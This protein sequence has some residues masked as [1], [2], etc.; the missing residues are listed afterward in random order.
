MSN[1]IAS[2]GALG[3]QRGM[4]QVERAAAAVARPPASAADPAA[5][6]V[7]AKLG[8]LQVQASAKV[9]ETADE[10]LGRLIDDFA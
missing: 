5:A 3:I 2:F 1:T 6:L 7:E 8:K 4:Q 9:L 10:P